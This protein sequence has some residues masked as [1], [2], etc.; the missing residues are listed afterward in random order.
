[1]VEQ[2]LQKKADKKSQK[3]E[4]NQVYEIQN[5]LE[6]HSPVKSSGGVQVLSQETDTSHNLFDFKKGDTI[7]Q[8]KVYDSVND[9]YITYDEKPQEKTTI[10][11]LN[12]IN[13]K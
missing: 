13:K 11:F 8:K 2:Y 5:L 12:P 7:T 1:M 9:S 4:H 10:K 6:F 3:R